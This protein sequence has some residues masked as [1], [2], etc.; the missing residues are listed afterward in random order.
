MSTPHHSV[1]S[2]R[3]VLICSISELHGLPDF[4]LEPLSGLIPSS[5]LPNLPSSFFSGQLGGLTLEFAVPEAFRS[6]DDANP[7]THEKLSP[8]HV[9]PQ[10]RCPLCAAGYLELQ[11]LRGS[12]VYGQPHLQGP[13]DLVCPPC[14]PSGRQAQLRARRSQARDHCSCALRFV[15]CQGKNGSSWYGICGVING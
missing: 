11:C 8:R 5:P 15:F 2:F 14:D 10:R 6:G 12:L 3:D 13:V 1:T 4:D 7:T 9:V